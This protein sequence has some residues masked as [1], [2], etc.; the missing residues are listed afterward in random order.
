MEHGGPHNDDLITWGKRHIFCC[1]KRLTNSLF[2]NYRPQC[3]N[4]RMAHAIGLVWVFW[5]GDDSAW[6]PQL[7]RPPFRVIHHNYL[8]ECELWVS[9][10]WWRQLMGGDSR[11]PCACASLEY[12][13]PLPFLITYKPWVKG[14]YHNSKGGKAS[15]DFVGGLLTS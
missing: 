12:V 10:G 9:F 6:G 3:E 15:V 1:N 4:M 2:S 7:M 13:D 11:S 14:D 8:F 5:L